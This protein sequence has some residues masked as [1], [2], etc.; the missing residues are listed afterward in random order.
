MVAARKNPNQERLSIVVATILLAYA[1]AQFVNVPRSEFPLSVLG[2]YIPIPVNFTTLVTLA[3]AGMTASGTD[4][5]LRDHPKQH[6]RSTLPHLLLPALTAWSLNV[7][8]TN[9]T[10][11]PV[12]WLVFATGGGF[13]ILVILAEFIA[14]DEEDLRYPIA[15]AL[16]NALSYAIFLALVVSL[17]SSGQRLILTLP[18]ISLAAGMLGLR[19]INL[20]D[21]EHWHL[22]QAAA[23]LVVVS[24]FAAAL[25]Y[26]P[27]QPISFGIFLLGALYAII[28]FTQNILHSPFT[29]RSLGEPVAVIFLLWI[30]ALWIN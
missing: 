18:V 14:L 25:F 22:P 30:L 5:L 19:I 9:I 17:R 15:V 29:R 28:S 12:F 4:W 8:L 3:V 6:E 1:L 2:V 7:I 23:G 21:A 27:I 16:L 20:K 24:Q 11:G 13:L 26:L 10:A